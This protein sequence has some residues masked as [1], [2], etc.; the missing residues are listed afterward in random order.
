MQDL[1]VFFH[2]LTEGAIVLRLKPTDAH[3]RWFSDGF[4]N[5]LTERLLR[6]Y[7]G[8]DE[9][10]KFAAQYDTAPYADLEK[11]LNLR[12]WLGAAYGIHTS[13]ESEERLENARYA[14]ATL[15]AKQFI[16][17]FGVEKIAPV[18]AKASLSEGGKSAGLFSA[19]WQVTGQ[20]MEAHLARYQEFKTDAEA[21]VRYNTAFFTEIT[22]K[23]AG[24][25]LCHTLR[26]NEVTGGS[27]IDCYRDAANELRL[28]GDEAAGA[29]VLAKELEQL[30]SRGRN[31]FCCTLSKF[32]V[33]FALK[34]KDPL[35]EKEAVLEAAE[36][37]SNDEPG[38]GPALKIKKLAGQ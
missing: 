38:F 34:C 14:Y 36:I 17:R 9:A 5:A 21:K 26:Y 4:A 11:Q 22:P 30:K 12:Y 10:R 15:V 37:A 32:F 6:K 29:A 16:E 23:N 27:E 25:E 31:D 19:I 24:E 33:V 13:L 28:M 35:Q 8:E 2:E 20:D 3:F 7:V 1:G 18:L